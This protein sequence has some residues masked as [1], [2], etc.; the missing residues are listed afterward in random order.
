MS[1]IDLQERPKRLLRRE[2]ISLP[3]FQADLIERL[4]LAKTAQLG[5]TAL[6][7]QIGKTNW[8]ID[9]TEAG[10][11]LPVST[12]TSVPL[13]QKWF[14][15]LLNIRGELS[16]VIDLNE[17]LGLEATPLSKESRILSFNARLDAHAA[18]LISRMLGLKNLMQMKPTGQEDGR[19]QPQFID[20]SE[21]Q[22][23]RLSLKEL[24]QDAKFL[25]VSK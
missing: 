5:T 13:T 4:R 15:G 8:L 12:P 9:L 6:G 24:A 19:G 14:K 17:F 23:T 11:I 7:V 3:N 18:I 20:A 21:Q 16:S 10:E 1:E 25:H 22:W 2:K